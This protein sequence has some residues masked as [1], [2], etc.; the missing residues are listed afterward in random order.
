LNT[1]N[2]FKV[3]PRVQSSPKA[4]NN[5]QIARVT[6]TTGASQHKTGSRMAPVSKRKASH[7]KKENAE[8]IVENKQSHCGVMDGSSSKKEEEVKDADDEYSF[9]AKRPESWHGTNNDVRREYLTYWRATQRGRS[10][11][12]K[13]IVENPQSYIVQKKLRRCRHKHIKPRPTQYDPIDN[14]IADVDSDDERRSERCFLL[15]EEH[16]MAN[17]SS[18]GSR[19]PIFGGSQAKYQRWGHY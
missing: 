12:K 7:S 15:V 6:G 19:D 1:C 13:K 4:T 2:S 11:L 16:K 17:S 8:M 10:A 3:M 9:F 18:T 5:D 14:D